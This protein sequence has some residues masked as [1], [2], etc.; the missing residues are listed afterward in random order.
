M[1]ELFFFKGRD[2]LNM[3]KRHLIPFLNAPDNLNM[4]GSQILA[5]E[6]GRLFS[7]MPLIDRLIIRQRYEDLPA[8]TL[9]SQRKLEI[10]NDE[11]LS[12]MQKIWFKAYLKT[13]NIYMLTRRSAPITTQQ[14]HDYHSDREHYHRQEA[15]QLANELIE[16][17][18]QSLVELQQR[19]IDRDQELIA[20]RA[21]RA[22]DQ[23]LIQTMRQKMMATNQAYVNQQQAL[24]E[25]E[26]VMQDQQEFLQ[27]MDAR[28]RDGRE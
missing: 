24:R 22:E 7:D 13:R 14:R 17:Q 12:A 28:E 21:H 18:R 6:E 3:N 27:E 26:F 20:E 19:L 23:R 11:T 2:N 10:M 1:V 4:A 5:M 8:K 16:T 15:N 25:Q 9:T